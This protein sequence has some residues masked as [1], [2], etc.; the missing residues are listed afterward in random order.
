MV[1]ESDIFYVESRKLSNIKYVFMILINS[2]CLKLLGTQELPGHSRIGIN[3]TMALL[4]ADSAS[5]EEVENPFEMGKQWFKLGLSE[6]PNGQI[7]EYFCLFVRNNR[8]SEKSKVVCS[9]S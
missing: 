3:N 1:K 4:A 7:A 5:G 9:T 8:S 6:C 2:Y